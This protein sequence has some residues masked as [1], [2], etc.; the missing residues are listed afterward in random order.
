[1]TQQTNSEIQSSTIKIDIDVFQLIVAEKQSLEKSDNEALRRLFLLDHPSKMG[2][3]SLTTKGVELPE[4]RQLNMEYNGNKNF[5]KVV[6]GELSVEGRNDNSPS[7][8]AVARTK[9]GEKTR[10]N[11]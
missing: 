3:G 8:A 4:G 1:M 2:D 6:Q 10:L 9:A 11:G 7:Q 5:G